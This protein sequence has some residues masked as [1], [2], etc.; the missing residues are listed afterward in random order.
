VNWGKGQY[1]I[2]V[3]NNADLAVGHRVKNDYQTGTVYNTADLTPN[4]QYWVRIS[5]IDESGNESDPTAATAVTTGRIATGDLGDQIVTAQQILA[6]TITTDLMTVNSIDADRIQANTMDVAKLKAS[7]LIAKIIT[8]GAGGQFFAGNPGGG[9]GTF[10]LVL[11]D[12]GI[13]LYNGATVSVSLDALT[14]NASFTGDVHASTGTLGDLTVTGTLTGGSINGATITGGVI[15]TGSG[16]PRVELNG[17]F[18]TGVKFFGPSP[19]VIEGSIEVSWSTI[20]QYGQLGIYGPS[21]LTSNQPTIKLISHAATTIMEIV[22][23]ADE[24]HVTNDLFVESGLSVVDDMAVGGNGSITGDFIVYGALETGHDLTMNDHKVRFRSSSNSESVAQFLSSNGTP[25]NGS[26]TINGP[27]ISGGYAVGLG[28]APAYGLG[29]RVYADGATFVN[30]S[31]NDF[32]CW[33]DLTVDGT[34]SNPSETALKSNIRSLSDGELDKIL[35]LKP[36]SFEYKSRPGVSRVGFLV[37][38]FESIYPDHVV[39]TT[40]PDGVTTRGI[41]YIGL[42]VRYAKAIQELRWELEQLKKN[43]MKGSA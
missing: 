14:G 42:S 22:L 41:D 12:Q 34:F 13:R 30:D 10:G 28:G 27:M 17:S 1:H 32:H 33:A 43:Y 2:E 19:I 8:L 35:R 20:S 38:D 16:S 4:T 5:A 31:F 29:F 9:A 11:N 40:T 25:A 6:G 36:K 7:S 24:V 26:Q 23:G 21:T 18:N 3:F 39:S 15:R 37:E